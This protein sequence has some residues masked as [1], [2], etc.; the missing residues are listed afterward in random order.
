M[1]AAMRPF[2]LFLALLGAILVPARRAHGQAD[3]AALDERAELYDAIGARAVEAVGDENAKVLI[4]SEAE[5]GALFLFI[6][7]QL[8]GSGVVQ[9][10]AGDPEVEDALHR[11]WKASCASTPPECWRGLV[12]L[13]DAGRVTARLLYDGQVDD[14][15]LYEKD[16]ALTEELFPGL[17][18]QL[19]PEGDRPP[20][21]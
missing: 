19:V 16:L 6:R 12:Y 7:Y 17:P 4:Y 3:S 5:G 9:Q 18:V 14:R 11:L 13:V 15:T 2:A 8:P 10:L 21:P 1:S 20:P